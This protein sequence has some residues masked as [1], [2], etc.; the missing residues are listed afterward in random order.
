MTLFELKNEIDAYKRIVHASWDDGVNYL[1]KSTMPE[2]PLVIC[3]FMSM[4]IK[5][6]TPT[7]DELFS[8]EWEVM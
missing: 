4:Q 2:S 1:I 3:D 6:F 8:D 7:I 5:N